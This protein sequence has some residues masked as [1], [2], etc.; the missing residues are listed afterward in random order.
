MEEMNLDISDLIMASTL[1][2]L[3]SKFITKTRW[4]RRR[5]E[6]ELIQRI[7]EYKEV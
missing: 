3:K 6:E 1:I 4:S 7:I 5:T 2:Y